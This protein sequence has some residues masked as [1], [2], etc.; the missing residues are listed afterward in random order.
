M[1][2]IRNLDTASI[3][4]FVGVLSWPFGAGK[5]IPGG[6][7]VSVLGDIIPATFALVTIACAI[8]FIRFPLARI[9]IS[10]FAHITLATALLALVCLS[11]VGFY[12]DPY[13][14]GDVV[15]W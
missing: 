3:F 12:L 4:L 7:F 15:G 11:V 10:A 9:Q 6:P 1:T 8:P 2:S 13:S 14:R 5:V